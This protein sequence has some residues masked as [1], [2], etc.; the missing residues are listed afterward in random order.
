MTPAFKDPA[1]GRLTSE[2]RIYQRLEDARSRLEERFLEGGAVLM[3]ALDAVGDMIGV[4]DR[5]TSSL[6]QDTVD[7]TISELTATADELHALPQL[8]ADRQSGME[9]LSE[10]GEAIQGDVD[11]MLETLRYLRTFAVTMK[12]TGA[13]ASDF[14]AFADEML[15]KIQTGRRQVDEFG[16]HLRSLREQVRTA[17]SLGR[18]LSG[19]YDG[20]VP[21]LVGDLTRDALR[22]GAHHGDVQRVATTLGDLARQVQGKVARVLSALQIGDMTRQRVEHVQ[23]GLN[24]FADR[25]GTARGS[26]KALLLALL[27]AQMDDLLEEFHSGC[28]TAT[29]SLGGLAADVKE[30]VA[31]GRQARGNA[32]SSGDG[33]LRG[34][35]RSLGSARQLVTEI[36]GAASRASGISRSSAGTAR[37]L[38]EK[39]STIQAIRS[40]IQYMAINTSLRCSRMGT[41]GKPMNVVA[42]EL[43]VFAQNMETISERLLAGLVRLDDAASDARIGGAEATSKLG[44]GL[45]AALEGVVQAGARVADDLKDLS[46]RGDQVSR[47]VGHGVSRLDFTRELGEVLE[48]CAVALAQASADADNDSDGDTIDVNALAESLFAT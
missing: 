48:E 25:C 14:T 19:Q 12:V 29:S 36:E 42:A 34:L 21:E 38:I 22:M 32:D 31:L 9:R 40:D 39:V 10:A 27:T 13:G 28:A 37:E 5:V 4:L 35:E 24:L 20:V 44:A 26:D 18:D 30:I 45:D 11:A 43:R 33:F 47:S 23:A 3:Q 1:L 8:Q 41:D 7:A 17:V 2:A 16:N 15:D 46:I 6:G